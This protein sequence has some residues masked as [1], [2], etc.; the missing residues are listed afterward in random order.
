VE[1]GTWRLFLFLN[2]LAIWGRF[3]THPRPI[4]VSMGLPPKMQT[5]KGRKSAVRRRRRLIGRRRLIRRRIR[6]MIRLMANKYE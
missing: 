5:G 1:F 4:N 2:F 3:G 6:L